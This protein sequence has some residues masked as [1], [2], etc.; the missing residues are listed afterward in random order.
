MAATTTTTT[1]K[2]PDAAAQAPAGRMQTPGAPAVLSDGQA[3]EVLGHLLDSRG[4]EAVQELAAAL[5]GAE[6]SAARIATAFGEE[7]RLGRSFVTPL[8][9]AIGQVGGHVEEARRLRVRLAGLVK[10]GSAEAAAVVDGGYPTAATSRDEI[11]AYLLDDAGQS[12]V[13]EVRLA[14]A[15]GMADLAARLDIAKADLAAFKASHARGVSLGSH[16]QSQHASAH[17]RYATLVTTRDDLTARLAALGAFTARVPG[18][19]AARVKAAIDAAGGPG[20]A[21]TGLNEAWSISP[22]LRGV[23]HGA[24]EIAARAA[25]LA[26]IEAQ[27]GQLDPAGGGSLAS[28]LSA[29]R[30]RAAADLAAAKSAASDRAKLGAAA[31]VDAAITGDEPA[32]AAIETAARAQPR[33]FVDGFARS[34]M[35][36]QFEWSSDGPEVLDMI[37]HC[38]AAGTR[39]ADGFH[40]PG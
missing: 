28:A 3:A 12:Y 33:A 24:A 7:R 15:A 35:E 20:A 39:Q 31:I 6:A 11:H 23:D 4:P 32:R 13:N 21:A 22:G 1:T 34:I 30:D 10:L 40:A 25:T 8:R 29:D 17:S 2:E 16:Q 19:Q 38:R 18:I 36:A 26:N 37:G 27:L 14:L 9:D 5:A